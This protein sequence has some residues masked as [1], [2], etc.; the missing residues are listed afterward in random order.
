[1]ATLKTDYAKGTKQMPVASG[2]EVVAVRMEYSLAAAL[3]LNDVL[4]LGDLPA[5]HVPV[6]FIADS[7]DVDSGTPA[8]IFQA[9]IL[10][11]GLTAVDTTKSGGA[12]W[13]GSSNIGQA[14]GI[15]RASDK[16][17]TRVPV[18][19]VNDLPVGIVVTTGPGTGT[20]SGKVAGTLLYR[21][22]HGGK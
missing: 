4:H 1:M 5:G 2:A 6:D 11:T 9:G 16:A 7:D 21:S 13:I 8:I 15:A 19:N 10:N 14:G 18:D 22:A 20:T 17:I 12:S 3:A